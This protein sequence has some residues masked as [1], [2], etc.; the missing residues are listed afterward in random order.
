MPLIFVEQSL[1]KHWKQIAFLLLPEKE[2]KKLAIHTGSNANIIIP[3]DSYKTLGDIQSS[4]DSRKS[5]FRSASQTKDLLL[6]NGE[7]CTVRTYQFDKQVLCV[8][9][10]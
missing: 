5:Q 2:K 3:S 10:R 4:A 1:R 9:H 7:V 8:S 6:T